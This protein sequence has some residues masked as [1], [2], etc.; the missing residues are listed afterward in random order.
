MVIIYFYI[1]FSSPMII[2]DPI[3]LP[4]IHRLKYQQD[5]QKIFRKTLQDRVLLDS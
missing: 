4:L 2:K 5:D 1:Y 3:T